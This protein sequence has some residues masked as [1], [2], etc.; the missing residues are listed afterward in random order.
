[1]KRC[2]KIFAFL[3][4]FVIAATSFELPTLS[5]QAQE[6]EQTVATYSD[7]G[8]A[9]IITDI[10]VGQTKVTISTEGEKPQYRFVPETTGRYH[11]YAVSESMDTEGTLYDSE[12]NELY[13][14]DDDSDN[15]NSRDFG[16]YCTL[17]AGEEYI[18]EV[19]F[20]NSSDTG[21]FDIIVEKFAD[22]RSVEIGEHSTDFIEGVP[23]AYITMDVEI[24]LEDGTKKLIKKNGT[25]S[26]SAFGQKFN[27]W[28]KDSDG[29]YT[30]FDSNGYAIVYSDMDEL[31]AGTYT[32]EIRDD[33]KVSDESAPAEN[34]DGYKAK[35]CT[36]CKAQSKDK[37]IIAKINT[38]TLKKTSYVYDGKG[39]KPGVTVKDSR[40]KTISKQ[41]YTVS[42]SNNTAVGTATVTV[43]FKGNYQGQ[44]KKT[45]VIN[46]AAV[47]VKGLENVVGGVKI[48]WKKSASGASYLIYRKAKKGSFKKVAAVANTGTTSY[49][50]ST[51]KN[52]TEY[53]YRIVAYKKSGSTSYRA[54]AGTAKTALYVAAP[55]LTG[56]RNTAKKT[57][58]VKWKKNTKATGYEIQYAASKSF[59]KAKI[60]NITS[61]KNVT[62]TIK[63]LAKNKRYYVRV[64]AYKR[65]GQTAMYYSGWSK[66]KNVKIKK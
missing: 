4:A 49:I 6:T 47:N 30:G 31:E 65:Q 9:A 58:V 27:V 43:T 62:K 15:E 45:F 59:K 24:I 16:I 55:K 3:M 57:A 25:T 26:F 44:V 23:S 22:I 61:K 34:K 42:Y 5:V 1:M 66:A 63:G 20:Y 41:N 32:V 33:Q 10:T 38:V 64:R 19:Q 12:G 13:Y 51:A 18:L 35:L 56:F 52:A 39:K 48:S 54:K 40:N 11:I 36:R 21:S 53:T 17:T 29:S 46:P 37:Q 7:A 60:V 14:N 28:I 50:D 2:K 8:N